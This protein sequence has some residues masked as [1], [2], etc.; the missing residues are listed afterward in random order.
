[1]FFAYWAVFCTVLYGIRPEDEKEEMQVAVIA[2]ANILLSVGL[3]F[4]QAL[5]LDLGKR[6]SYR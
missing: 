3:S 4:P 2:V 1:M 6:Q 5:D